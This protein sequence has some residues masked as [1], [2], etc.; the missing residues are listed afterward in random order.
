MI[1]ALF[2]LGHVLL[3]TGQILIETLQHVRGMFHHLPDV[4]FEQLVELVRPDVVRG[5]SRSP[6]TVV[7]TA[8]VRTLEILA[9]HGEHGTAAVA[10][11]QKTRVDI[12]VLF[13]AAIVRGRALFAQ[14]PGDCERAVVNDRLMMV[15]DHDLFVLGLPDILAVDLLARVLTL[16]QRADVKVVVQ[17]TLYGHNR[18]GC[19]NRTLVFLTSRLFA[20]TLG[21]TRGRDALLG[22]IVCDFFVTPAFLVVQTEDR[23]HNVGLSGDD[24]KLLPLVDDVSVGCSADP[25]AVSLSALDDIFYLFAG[26]RDRHLVDEELKLDF[27]PVIIVGKVDA[28]TDGNDAHAG[29]T[30]IFQLN[31]TTA[32][33]ARKTGKILDNED[34]ILVTH[35][36][37][38][39]CL[40]ALALFKRVTGAVTILVE[41]EGAARE[42][43]FDKVLNDRLLVF[44]GHVVPIQ[45]VIDRNS[46]VTRNVKFF[47]HVWLPPFRYCSITRSNS[48]TYSSS[49]F[50][51]NSA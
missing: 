51:R 6:A 11:D 3:L 5:T 10:A 27:Q 32:V 23:A 2:G 4:A 38:A 50:L 30:Q 24:L 46:A 44:D 28:V 1:G 45:I 17:N 14:G 15:L 8:G 9:A 47:D 16:T 39:Q 34:F 43:L 20:V 21:H 42:F 7:G 49:C 41:G 12:V 25:L 18:P 35:Q 48:E 36:L 33:A 19:L 29:I 26:I 13:D 22:Q 40:I 31:Q 37:F